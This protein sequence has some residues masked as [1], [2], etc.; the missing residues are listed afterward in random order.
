MKC[1]KDR[2]KNSYSFYVIILEQRKV[3]IHMFRNGDAGRY[4]AQ[5]SAAAG[6]LSTFGE[7]GTWMDVTGGVKGCEG[8]Q[9]DGLGRVYV[10]VLL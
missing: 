2:C 5:R 10:L 8:V 3:H 6:R 9:W 7:R 1:V 4:A